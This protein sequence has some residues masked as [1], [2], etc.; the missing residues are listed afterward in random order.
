ME[1]SPKH[2]NKFPMV[3]AIM[4][5][6]GSTS[7]MSTDLYAPSLPYLTSYF[8]TTPELIKLTISLNIIVY[9]LAQL[10][11]GPLSDRFGRR[12]ILLYSIVLFSIASVACA[13]AQNINQLLIARVLQGIF[14]AAETV[15]WTYLI[16][17]SRFS[18][19]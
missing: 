17:S 13:F 8:G 7:I 19:V 10:I 12:P 9:G 5:L 4:V 11:Y 2:V 15:I 16:K 1:N 14:A 6:A 3:L 18:F